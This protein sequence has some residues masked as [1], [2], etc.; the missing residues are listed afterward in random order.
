MK[1]ILF[2]DDE[3]KILT[4]LR[5]SLRSL[6]H[7]WEMVFAEGGAAALTQCAAAP[8]DVLVSDARM[9]GIEGSELLRTVMELYPGTARMILS[10]QCSR[11][12]VLECVA[13][14]HQFFSKPCDS[15][16][17]RSAVHQVCAMR[18]AFPDETIRA[19]ISR[20]Q[21]LPIQESLY[22]ELAV[23]IES[24]EASIARVAEIITRDIGMAAKVVQLVS[25]GFFGS[26]QHV[27]NASQ[28][29]KLLGLEMI[30]ALFASSD[31]LPL[32]AGKDQV[33]KLQ[34]LLDHSMSVAD[35]AQRIMST[36]TDDCTLMR[37]AYLAGTLHE[38]G[39]LAA[40]DRGTLAPRGRSETTHRPD[41]T[42]GTTLSD[43]PREACPDSGGYLVALWGLPPSVVQAIAYHRVPSLCPEQML[44]PLTAI[45]IAHAMLEPA[46]NAYEP[47]TA[48]ACDYLQRTG[49]AIQLGRWHEIC[50][51]CQPGGVL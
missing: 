18:E 23:E 32:L 36:L 17:L 16:T 26:P 35:A 34:A 25:S 41:S 5:R 2:V 4:G 21:W 50:Q 3:P 45:H 49:C 14:A 31:G 44:S 15:E 46:P 6:R 20:T 12:S 33:E 48:I 24:P 9:P 28:A 40:A 51:A 38:A 13:V 29:A 22:W 37:D 7:E 1:R 11:A 27:A 43:N 42:R 30:R 10:G 19:A 8:F 39:T 47:N